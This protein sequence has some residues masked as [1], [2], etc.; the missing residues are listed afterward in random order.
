MMLFNKIRDAHCGIVLGGCGKVLF[1][2]RGECD[3]A[4][5]VS[6]R[7]ISDLPGLSEQVRGVCGSM[8]QTLHELHPLRLFI[9]ATIGARCTFHHSCMV[10]GGT[11]RGN[12]MV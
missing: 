12:S 7:G 11:I 6:W 8:Q 5:S 10:M 3:D 1:H 4:P 2:L 9:I